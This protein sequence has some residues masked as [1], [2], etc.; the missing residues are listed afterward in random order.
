MADVR[1]SSTKGPIDFSKRNTKKSPYRV[2]P[3]PVRRM[4]PVM[5]I[6]RLCESDRHSNQTSDS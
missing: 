2:A 5:L 4:K 1:T 3:V 6:S